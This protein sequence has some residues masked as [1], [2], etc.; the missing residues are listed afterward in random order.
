MCLYSR[1]MLL[2]SDSLIINL[3]DWVLIYNCVPCVRY[4]M[5]PRNS[6]ITCMLGC[7]KKC[8]CW[9]ESTICP[10]KL[11]FYNRLLTWSAALVSQT[12][13]CLQ[14]RKMKNQV[15]TNVITQYKKK[16][17]KRKKGKKIM[18]VVCYVW[19]VI[20]PNRTRSFSVFFRVWCVICDSPSSPSLC[21]K[22]LH[23]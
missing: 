15:Q 2:L 4:Y 14:W 18:C 1:K 16:K 20:S 22:S 10:L 21:N 8:R 5:T 6:R 11:Y 13:S 12:W 23:N 9:F 19:C 17:R 3:P 7:L